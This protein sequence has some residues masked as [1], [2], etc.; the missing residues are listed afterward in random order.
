[1]HSCGARVEQIQTEGFHE[2]ENSQFIEP[3]GGPRRRIAWPDCLCGGRS[4]LER[5]SISVRSSMRAKPS[6]PIGAMLLFWTMGKRKTMK[7][8]LKA[9]ALHL[10]GITDPVVPGT[11]AVHL[12]RLARG[13]RAKLPATHRW[14][15]SREELIRTWS[16]M[17]CRSFEGPENLPPAQRVFF[18]SW[19]F[20]L[21][22]CR[23]ID[24]WP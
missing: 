9:S 15:T 5:N 12:M 18:P 16:L 6:A 1:M 3:D 13:W 21:P 22:C 19:A 20:S 11:F 10:P 2:R 7:P 17:I 23:V 4:W 8:S 24:L 14:S